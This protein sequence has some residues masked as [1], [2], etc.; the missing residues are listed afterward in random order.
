[1]NQAIGKKCLGDRNSYLELWKEYAPY[2]RRPKDVQDVA[3]AFFQ[4]DDG[5]KKEE[6]EQGESETKKILFPV[7][8]KLFENQENEKIERVPKFQ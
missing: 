6:G 7:E 3:E 4:S 2:V 5:Q 8:A 1:M